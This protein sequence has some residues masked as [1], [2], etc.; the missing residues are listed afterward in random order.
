MELLKIEGI[1]VNEKPY[2]ETSKLL[3]I[4]SKELGVITVLA[5]GAKRPKSSLAG[6]TTKLVYGYFHILYKEDKLSILN[7]VDVI[8][9]L[10]NIKKDLTKIS[11][12]TYLCELTS[13]VMKQ[14]VSKELFDLLKY[15]ILQIERGF[16]P[17]MITNILEIKYLYFLGVEPN[18]NM[19]AVCGD[20]T[21]IITLSPT[22][23]GYVCKSCYT[24]EKIV[25]NKTIKLIR[26]LNYID[27]SKIT[28]MEIED[29]VILEVNEFID[30]YYDKYTGLYLKTKSFLNNITKITIS[31]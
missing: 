29:K 8:N 21:S 9:P 18:F 31:N 15:G 14:H 13:Q 16:N 12:L 17:M 19:C 1:I 6:V 2:S 24:N 3:T 7:E 28:K 25:S 30:N 11:Y 22:K 4:L 23:G 10:I 5:K 26:L 27:I 20:K